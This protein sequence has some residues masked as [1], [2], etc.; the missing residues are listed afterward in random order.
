M[1]ID[2]SGIEYLKECLSVLN[3][4]WSE[5]SVITDFVAVNLDHSDSIEGPAPYL[6]LK[7]ITVGSFKI[8][9]TTKLYNISR[10]NN[11]HACMATQ[12]EFNEWKKR[13]DELFFIDNGDL[14]VFMDISVKMKNGSD[15]YKRKYSEQLYSN[16]GMWSE[17]V[18]EVLSAKKRKQDSEE[19]SYLFIHSIYTGNSYSVD[20]WYKISP[21]GDAEILRLSPFDA[22]IQKFEKYI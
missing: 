21:N 9:V 19:E 7:K 4:Y 17:T 12:E 6:S 8:R 11:N 16:D 18:R 1:E 14:R 22:G 5:D 15:N 3:E 20:S 13:N 10:K 2:A